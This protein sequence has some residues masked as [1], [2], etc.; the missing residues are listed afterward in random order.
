MRGAV[1]YVALCL[2]FLAI[3]VLVFALG[4]DAETA[5]AAAIT[6]AIVV[7]VLS[8]LYVRT[9]YLASPEPRSIFWGMLVSA[10]EVK[11]AFGVWVGY[12]LV[13]TRLDLPV[14]PQ[15]HR[16][17]ITV[18]AAIGLFVSATYYAVTIYLERRAG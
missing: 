11:V 14:P 12:L 16:G 4:G 9:K 15:P 1:L 17:L 2:P 10:L 18:G 8:T 6:A 7:G 3:G 13:A 5:T